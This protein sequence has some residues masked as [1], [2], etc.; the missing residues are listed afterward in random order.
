MTISVTLTKTGIDN[1]TDLVNSTNIMSFANS[2]ES[3]FNNVLN[4]V[5]A[6][7]K[8]LFTAAF[9]M[10]IN[11]GVITAPT[12]A[13][14]TL[15]SAFDLTP[16]SDSLHTIGVSNNRFV[17]MK[18]ASGH[19]ITILN[20]AGNI[21]TQDGRPLIL[22]GNAIAMAFCIGSQWAV[23][24][25]G[26]SGIVN[27]QTATADPGSGEDSG[28]GYSAGSIWVNVNNKRIWQAVDTTATLAR[29]VWV[30]PPKNR[31][32]VRASGAVAVGVGVANPTVANAPAAANDAA[33]SYMTLPS[34]A[35]IGNLGGLITTTLNLIRPAH[36]PVIEIYMKT[37]ADVSSVRI[38]IG[39]IDAELTNVDTLAAGREFIGF[40]FS[41]VAADGGFKPILHDGTTQNTGTAIGTVAADTAYKLRM[42]VDSANSRVYF[43]VNDSAEQMLSTNFPSSAQD[44][45]L[46]MR[47]IPQAASIRSILL[48]KAEVAWG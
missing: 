30:T 5:Q 29:W 16:F 1:T 7:D 27:N 18:A 2:V 22:S 41:T 48:S 43:S 42:R 45:G 26:S 32:M 35:S 36:D 15:T 38:W 37:G 31:W 11:N 4:G 47:V 20:G 21:T 9:N 3:M 25:P 19:T 28:D 44:L 6:F 10:G 40:R 39:L 34:T 13:L 24:G 14:I 46:V 17:V 8:Q 23:I 33:N 12:Q